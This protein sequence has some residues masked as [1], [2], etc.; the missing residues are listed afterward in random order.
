[1]HDGS[2]LPPGSFGE[3]EL[4]CTDLP[5]KPFYRAY[6]SKYPQPLGFK[7]S[8][9]RF[10]D[11]R[12]GEPSYDPYGTLYIGE[13]FEVCVLETIIRDSGIGLEGKALPI[14]EDDL[15]QWSIAELKASEPM[16]FLDLTGGG[17]VALQIPT[18]AI[19]AKDHSLGQ[20]WS[21]AI[22]NHPDAPDGLIF[23]SRLNEQRNAAVFSRAIG[24][25]AVIG[26]Q[27]IIDM[28]DEL[29]E[30]LEKYKIALVP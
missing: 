12:I 5:N 27:R 24:P 2:D 9:S 11:P 1:M 6:R 22:H 16:R 7:P 13:S 30:L 26:T 28:Q 19:R 23:S 21:E 4:H 8:P 10:S 14:S 18:D 3:R 17:A 29:A 25:L 15:S 20:A